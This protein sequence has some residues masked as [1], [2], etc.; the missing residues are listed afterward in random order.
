MTATIGSE[1]RWTRSL[2]LTVPRKPVIWLKFS[3]LFA[4]YCSQE[5]ENTREIRSGIQSELTHVYRV[6]RIGKVAVKTGRF[7]IF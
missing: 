7:P 2:C 6:E 3:G 1:V 4:G 5:P